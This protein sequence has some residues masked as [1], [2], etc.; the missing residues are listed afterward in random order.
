M[1]PTTSK[2]YT[3]HYKLSILIN[4]GGLSF[5]ISNVENAKIV[6]LSTD[7]FSEEKNPEYLGK[8]VE[9][10][11]EYKLGEYKNQIKEVVA[12]YANALY[13]FV[14][15]PIF[16]EKNLTDYL[17]YNIK[18]LQTDIP[19]VDELQ[20][21]PVNTVFIPYTNINNYLFEKFGAF[22]FTHAAS[23]LVN[24]ALKNANTENSVFIN[25]QDHS[26]DICVVKNKKMILCNSFPKAC[27]EDFVYYTLFVFEQLLLDTEETPISLM[28][29]I[30]KNTPD[31]QLLYKYVRHINFIKK[32]N[33]VNVEQRIFA[34]QEYHQQHLLVSTLCE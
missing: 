2:P 12:I 14:P 20:E 30:H 33:E 5:C 17:K 18:I 22:T 28:G 11:I 26:F 21:S 13:T 27:A 16:D 8:Q 34:D 23:L 15:R 9:H 19:A 29:E 25:L 6:Y 4:Q 3:K 31:Y 24:I 7:K 10:H 32:N 1:D